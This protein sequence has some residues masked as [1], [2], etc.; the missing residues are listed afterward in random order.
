MRYCNEL[1]IIN[2]LLTYPKEGIDVTREFLPTLTALPRYLEV[3]QPQ[4]LNIEPTVCEIEKR[5][6]NVELTNESGFL[7]LDITCLNNHAIPIS[8]V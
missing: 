6:R 7:E 2:N 5:K 4:L 1:H 8:I 3:V